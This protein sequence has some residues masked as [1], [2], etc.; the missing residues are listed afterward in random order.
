MDL[1]NRIPFH[2]DSEQTKIVIG[3][4]NSLT[5]LTYTTAPDFSTYMSEA[6][7]LCRIY[8]AILSS[9]SAMVISCCR[10]HE[11]S[12]NWQGSILVH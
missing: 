12:S 2:Y 3:G 11:M 10:H 1:F 5:S 7:L 6:D 4:N 9:L 8:V